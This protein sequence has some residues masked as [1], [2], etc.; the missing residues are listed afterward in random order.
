MAQ[1]SL[2]DLTAAA[3]N[4]EEPG[5]VTFSKTRMGGVDPLGLRQLNFDLMNEVLPG[6]NNVARHV[7]PFVVLAWAWRRAGQRAE[8]MGWTHI[9]SSQLQDFVD[10]IEVLFVVSQLLQDKNVDLPGR[11]YLAPWLAESTFTFGGAGWTKRR[12]ER[13][14]STGLAA[15]INY[16]P[17]LK[18]LGWVEPHPKY[19][20]IMLSTPVVTPAL[21]SLE[22]GLR[23]ALKH[24]A[25]NSFDSITVTRKQVESWG[26]LWSMDRITDDEARVMGELLMGAPAALGRRLGVKLMLA[27]SIQKKSTDTG[28]LRA[29]MSGAPSRFKPPPDL[30]AIRDVWRAVQVRQLFRLSLESLFYWMM[31][32][33]NDGMPRS[34]DVLVGALLDSLPSHSTITAGDWIRTLTSADLGPTELMERIQHA[35]GSE[36]HADLPDCVA[37][38]LAFCLTEPTAARL[39]QTARLPLTRAQAEA[40]ARSHASVPEFMRHVLESWVLAQHAYWAVGRGLADARSGGGMLLRLRIIL[41]EGGWTLAP[42]ASAGGAPQPTPDRLATAIAL[43]KECRLI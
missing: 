4:A 30:V 8:A 13:A 21:D 42:G 2:A 43:A 19:P 26:A 32:K 1:P 28:A 3:A 5:F 22:A 11:D 23:P 35:W 40:A 25:F 9:K 27:A 16:G 18:M 37:R 15:P 12:R 14:Y 33:L 20:G 24:E 7:R 38:G 6:L 34:I 41:D 31:L 39:Q 10:R 36:T 17:G 29:A